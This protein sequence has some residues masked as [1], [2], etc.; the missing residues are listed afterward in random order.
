MI[1][2][3]LNPEKQAKTQAANPLTQGAIKYGSRSPQQWRG[4]TQDKEGGPSDA[5]QGGKSS[6]ATGMQNITNQ[7]AM[8]S[9]AFDF[10]KM[11]APTPVSLFM[12]AA[13]AISQQQINDQAAGFGI[14]AG[15]VEAGMNEGAANDQ[16]NAPGGGLSGKNAG[17]GALGTGGQGGID[18]A[19]DDGPSDGP[20]FITTATAQ[21]FGW[22]DDCAVLQTLRKFRDNIVARLP[23]GKDDIS[24]YYNVAPAIAAKLTKPECDHVWENYIKRS[25][26]AI[27]AGKYLRAYK[28]YKNMMIKLQDGCK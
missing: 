21:N 6:P 8:R 18:S 26:K 4:N 11:I 5:S 13:K 2:P 16:D 23:N 7:I 24:T 22:S 28:I 25:V 17:L 10:A 20:C 14:S 12:G 27:T 9:K 15:Q 19:G 3:T 1:L